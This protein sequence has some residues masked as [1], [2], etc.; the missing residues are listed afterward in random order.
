[1]R[2]VKNVNG[3]EHEHYYGMRMSVQEVY[4]VSGSTETLEKEFIYDGLDRP[5]AM[6]TMGKKNLMQLVFMLKCINAVA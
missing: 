3:G 4:S 1:M 5:V 2:S 6:L